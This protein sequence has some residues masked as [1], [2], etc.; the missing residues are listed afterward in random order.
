MTRADDP[1]RI[2]LAEEADVR[3]VGDLTVRA[4][5]DG[6]YVTEQD[7]YTSQLRAAEDRRRAAELWVA[8]VSGAVCGTVTFCPPGSVYRELA[9]PGDGE[10]RMLA[11]DPAARGRGLGRA[12]VR[13]CAE[14]C[15]ELGLPGLVLCSLEEM[16]PAH[17]LY[18][19]LGFSRDPELDWEPEPGVC[20]IGFRADVQAV[21]AQ[22]RSWQ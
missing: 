19:S 7:G 4:Y 9:G 21:L 15:E 13:R 1:I 5:V 3:A 12:L 10:F 14:R 22:R 16:T 6:G 2:R 20:L 11:V 17:A 18:R 8:T